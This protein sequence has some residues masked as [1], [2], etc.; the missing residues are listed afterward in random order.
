MST[1]RP[2]STGVESIKTIESLRPGESLANMAIG[3]SICS[4]HRA[5]RFR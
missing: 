1:E 4:L 5:R 3:Q 2:H